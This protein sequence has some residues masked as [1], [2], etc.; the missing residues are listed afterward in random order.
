MQKKIAII[1]LPNTGKSQVFNNLTKGYT[2]VANYPFTTVEMKRAHC[3]IG[4][5]LY[6]VIDTPGLHCLYIHSEEELAVRDMLLSEEPDV[7]VQC[8]D[9]NRLKQS[10]FLTA[11][12]L[13]LG[14]PIHQAVGLTAD[15]LSEGYLKSRLNEASRKIVE[16]GVSF[17]ES[18]GQDKSFSP[19]VANLMAVGEAS[20]KLS[21]PLD[22][23]SNMYE[24]EVEESVKLVTSLLEPVMILLVGSFVGFL[25]LAMLLPV[26]TMGVVGG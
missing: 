5:E 10:L 13:E 17:A 1:G 15:T 24:K 3:R 14:I 23:I 22:E 26:F 18:M 6:E 7:I 4:D 19:L 25:I 9:A 12:L 8:I 20:G 2:L 16:E 11:D 21:G